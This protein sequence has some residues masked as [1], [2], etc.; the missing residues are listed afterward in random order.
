MTAKREQRANEEDA[1]KRWLN[2]VWLWVRIVGRINNRTGPLMAWEIAR[3]IHCSAS[4]ERRAMAHIR[5][6]GQ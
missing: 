3:S 4:E 1:M 2:A 6:E 5:G